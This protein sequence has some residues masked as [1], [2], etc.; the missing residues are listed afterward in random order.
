[1]MRIY[2]SAKFYVEKTRYPAVCVQIPMK[3]VKFAV[4]IVKISAPG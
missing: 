1:M 3:S 2:P 4:V